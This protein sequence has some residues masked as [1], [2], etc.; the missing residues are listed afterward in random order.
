MIDDHQLT[1]PVDIEYRRVMSLVNDIKLST[2]SE[3]ANAEYIRVNPVNADVVNGDAL[4]TNA[5]L[6]YVSPLAAVGVTF[7]ETAV[8]G[9]CD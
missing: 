6:A 9:Y 7:G 3:Y 4:M 2:V 8:A 5:V 1:V